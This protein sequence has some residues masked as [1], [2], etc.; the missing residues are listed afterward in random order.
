M[1]LNQLFIFYVK[2]KIRKFSVVN[3]AA[4]IFESISIPNK[5]D[6]L[7][8]DSREKIIHICDARKGNGNI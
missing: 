7:P 2:I 1:V 6:F 3:V 4:E 5:S 8:K